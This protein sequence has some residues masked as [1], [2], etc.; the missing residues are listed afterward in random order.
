[1]TPRE[2]WYTLDDIVPSDNDDRL[3]CISVDS[4]DKQFL[5]G[6]IGFPTHNSEQ[7]KSEDELK[8]EAAMIIG[9]IARLGR[10]AGVHLVIATQR[11]DATIIKGEVKAN[12][13]VRVNAGRTGSTASSM[14]LDNGEGTRVKAQPPGRLYLSMHGNGDHGQGFFADPSWI[15]EYLA[16]KGLNPDGTPLSKKRSRLANVTDMSQFEDGTLDEREGV[17]NSSAIE[18][19]REEESQDDFAE[20]FAAED[21]PDFGEGD[22]DDSDWGFDDDDDTPASSP[23]DDKLGRP[24]LSSES[25]NA[26]QWDRA[27]DDWDAELEDLIEENNS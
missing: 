20:A 22:I 17:D 26:N 24:D 15:D 4:P 25:T 10:A 16:S 13:A 2:E 5:A 18:R 1:M 3:Y 21:E 23:V 27:E 14:I 12:L 8:G 19:I 9:S 11:P 6:E 7:G